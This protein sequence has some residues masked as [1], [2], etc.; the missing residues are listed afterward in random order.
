MKRVPPSSIIRNIGTQIADSSTMPMRSSGMRSSV[1]LRM[2]SV[3]ASAA[4]VQRKIDSSGG[5]PPS[6]GTEYHTSSNTRR[7]SATWNTGVTPC[8]TNARHK[9][10][11]VGVRERAAVDERG[12]DHREVYAGALELGELAGEPLLVAQREVRDRVHTAAAVG[13]DGAAPAVPRAHVGG[14]R[15]QVLVERALPEQPEVGEHHRLVDAHLGELVG[16]RRRVPVVA[17]QDLVVVRQRWQPGADALAPVAELAGQAGMLHVDR[18][19]PA[20][21]APAQPRIA[22]VVV[23]DARA[24]RRG[25]S[26]RCGRARSSASRRGAGRNRSRTPCGHRRVP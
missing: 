26:G 13:D 10:V 25:G 6:S 22:E 7:W 4:A 11:V 9:R 23:D 12:R 21:G 15:R 24:R 16:A 19:E 8:C 20:V 3:H 1:P 5:R 2:R 18:A 17:R 14:E